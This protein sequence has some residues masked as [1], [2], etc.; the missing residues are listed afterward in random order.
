[1]FSSFAS[2]YAKNAAATLQKVQ[3]FYGPK[4]RVV[5]RSVVLE[6]MDAYRPAARAALAAHRQGTFWEMH[7][8]LFSRQ[9]A[10][11]R[12]SLLRY[13][14]QLR[15]DEDAFRVDMESDAVAAALEAD[16]KQAAAL[17]VVAVPTVFV[18]EQPL[19]G[20]QMLDSY[21]EVIDRALGIAPKE[22]KKDGATVSPD[23]QPQQPAP[24]PAEPQP[25]KRKKK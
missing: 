25:K 12:D 5:F 14:A 24:T 2:P 23:A 22:E 21:K 13:A 20:D 8:L 9:D 6:G 3:T 15:L 16:Q 17:G 1:V 11:D 18:N 7:D 19:L 4:V 10:L